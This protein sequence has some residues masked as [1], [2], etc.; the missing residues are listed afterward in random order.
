MYFLKPFQICFHRRELHLRFVRSVRLT[1]QHE[2]SRRHAFHFQR[3]VKLI[4]LRDRHADVCFT[5]LNHR[6]RRDT[7]NV[8]HR[9]MLLIEVHDFPELPAEIVGNKRRDIC[10]AIEAHQIC[11]RRA[12]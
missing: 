6:R 8:E 9:R 7:F 2:H 1:R 4:P 10:R 11:Y 3:I 12:G 5:V